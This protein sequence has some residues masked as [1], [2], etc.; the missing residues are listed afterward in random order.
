[1][2][3]QINHIR[4]PGLATYQ[5][6]EL[7]IEAVLGQTTKARALVQDY[8]TRMVFFDL[9]TELGNRFA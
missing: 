1:M 4:V 5:A 6:C 2:Q 3:S 7:A 9:G 8:V